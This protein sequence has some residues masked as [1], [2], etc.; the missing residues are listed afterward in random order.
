MELPC[1]AAPG[2]QEPASH[3]LILTFFAASIGH[4]C[5]G[6]L[7]RRRMSLGAP[8]CPPTMNNPHLPRSGKGQFP[9]LGTPTH[10]DADAGVKVGAGDVRDRGDELVVY[11][12]TAE[13]GAVILGVR[14][15][16][17]RLQGTGQSGEAQ[18]EARPARHRNRLEGFPPPAEGSFSD[19]RSSLWA[20]SPGQVTQRQPSAP[21]AQTCLHPTPAPADVYRCDY[22]KDLEMRPSWITQVALNP[23][24]RILNPHRPIE[25]RDPGKM[26]HRVDG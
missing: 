21:S 14:M 1:P 7:E 4:E 8:G 9:V 25:G 3:Q 22:V 19:R 24:T 15:Y 10:R 17:P 23:T 13:E 5:D 18:Q 2:V 6:A 20:Q 16:V 11:F 12:H 26:R